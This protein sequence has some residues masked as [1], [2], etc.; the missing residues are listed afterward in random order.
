MQ[1]QPGAVRL[2]DAAQGGKALGQLLAGSKGA[3]I[4]LLTQNF[5]GTL[6]QRLRA[7]DVLQR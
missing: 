7:V 1:K 4:I 3:W 6:N 5:V 2:L